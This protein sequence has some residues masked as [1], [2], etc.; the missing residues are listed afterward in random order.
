MDRALWTWIY[1]LTGL[2]MT[3]L[4]FWRRLREMWRWV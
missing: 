1:A 4:E 2:V 3:I